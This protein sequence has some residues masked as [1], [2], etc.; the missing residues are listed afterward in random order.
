MT[1]TA[2]EYRKM[3]GCGLEHIVPDG[4]DPD[5]DRKPDPAIQEAM[6]EAAA[7]PPSDQG[8]TSTRHVSINAVD[9][10]GMMDH[11]KLP[12][13][14]NEAC[15]QAITRTMLSFTLREDEW[16]PACLT[17]GACQ[18]RSRARP[19]VNALHDVSRE[20]ERLDRLETGHISM[21][22]RIEKLERIRK[23]ERLADKLGKRG[24]AQRLT[25]NRLEHLGKAI[26]NVRKD[27]GDWSLAM[28]EHGSAERGNLY[29]ELIEVRGKHRA[30]AE[31]MLPRVETLEKSQ[32][33]AD[34]RLEH[35][36]KAIDQA[37]GAAGD[38]YRQLQEHYERPNAEIRGQLDSHNTRADEFEGRIQ[39]LEKVK[40]RGISEMEGLTTRVAEL[41]GHGLP[42]DGAK[43]TISAL[44]E[45]ARLLAGA[46]KVDKL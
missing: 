46:D 19:D 40:A 25:D 9:E 32:D 4:P 44:K 2:D 43:E 24:S 8:G 28:R 37:Q 21:D 38:S 14:V 1:P 5:P 12:V 23:H 35:L 45:Y 34:N 20:E 33:F 29:E 26:E 15:H 6:E 42:M 7:T 27:A 17:N 13:Q 41:E 39:T 18:H 36:G 3:D 30:Y 16:C 31:E 22:A 11:Y 10:A